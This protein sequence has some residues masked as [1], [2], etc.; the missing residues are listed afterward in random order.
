MERVYIDVAHEGK[1]DVVLHPGNYRYRLK[2]LNRKGFRDMG[3]WNPHEELAAWDPNTERLNRSM[4]RDFIAIPTG[5]F[6]R[7][8][9]CDT[10]YYCR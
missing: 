1:G 5:A 2:L 10:P 3:V 7:P 9:T 8:V 6:A 4:H